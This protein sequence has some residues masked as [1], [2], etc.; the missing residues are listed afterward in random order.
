[1]RRHLS[2]RI[3]LFQLLTLIML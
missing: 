3:F 2:L 1:M